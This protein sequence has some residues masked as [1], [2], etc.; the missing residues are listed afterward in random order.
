MQKLFKISLMTESEVVLTN[1]QPS[2]ELKTEDNIVLLPKKIDEINSIL[3]REL[4]AIKTKVDLLS[5][6]SSG[7]GKMNNNNG[8]N[9]IEVNHFASPN[10]KT[11]DTINT[12]SIKQE[13]IRKGSRKKSSSIY[14][15]HRL[16]N[17]E[18]NYNDFTR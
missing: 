10:F 17:T 4:S 12:I 18:P 1:S 2:Q 9:A 5:I 13:P 7:L 14:E 3:D 16:L 11:F 8:L 15:M 6:K